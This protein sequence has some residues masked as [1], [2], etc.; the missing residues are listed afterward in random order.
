[1]ALFVPVAPAQCCKACLSN[2]I[3]PLDSCSD[4]NFCSGRGVCNL[5][6]CDCLDGYGGP[7]CGSQV[8]YACLVPNCG[9]FFWSPASQL[10]TKS[11]KVCP[12]C[13]NLINLNLHTVLRIVQEDFCWFCTVC[14]SVLSIW[15]SVVAIW[16]LAC[17]GKQVKAHMLSDFA[18]QAD[19]IVHGHSCS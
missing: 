18:S 12:N 3:H 10:D 16:K 14:S 11:C 5:G 8:S 1:M 17:S 19:T 7:D 6:T 9:H 4:L 13:S 15:H 2:K